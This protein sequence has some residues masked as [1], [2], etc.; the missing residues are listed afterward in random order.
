[1]ANKGINTSCIIYRYRLFIV[2]ILTACYEMP[3][4]MMYMYYMYGTEI[5][6]KM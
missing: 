5:H 1:M 6:K 2:K 3:Q 4:N